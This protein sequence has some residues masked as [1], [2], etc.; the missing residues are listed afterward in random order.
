MVT[1]GV[2]KAGPERGLAELVVDEVEGWEV[3]FPNKMDI[4]E[5]EDVSILKIAAINT[6][7]YILYWL[8]MKT[9]LVDKYHLTN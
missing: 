4:D 2:M 1:L 7:F 3:M 6:T 5:K 9:H 8:P